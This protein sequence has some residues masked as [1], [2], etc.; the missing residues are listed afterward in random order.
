MVVVVS[1]LT[2][3]GWVGSGAG[4]V[5][6]CAACHEGGGYGLGGRVDAVY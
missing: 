2:G 6:G 5:E 1:A 3:D 4:R